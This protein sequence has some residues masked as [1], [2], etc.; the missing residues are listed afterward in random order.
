MVPSHRLGILRA[1]ERPRLPRYGLLGGASN[2][3]PA[4]G[5]P[6][7]LAA[8]AASRK[9][10]AEEKRKAEAE[11]QNDQEIHS[12][13]SNG[14]LNRLEKRQ[15]LKLEVDEDKVDEARKG[16]K[17]LSIASAPGDHARADGRLLDSDTMDEKASTTK[18][19]YP[20]RYQQPPEQEA[21]PLQ[22]QHEASSVSV[23][24]PLVSE[25]EESLQAAPSS[26]ADSLFQSTQQ[27]DASLDVPSARGFDMH[28]PVPDDLQQ[29]YS[30]FSGP[31]P[32]DVV[33]RAQQGK[34]PQ[35]KPK[36]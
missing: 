32:D 18:R 25:F 13:G 28:F 1:P 33:I 31:S 30:P 9:K 12:G 29:N 23:Q 19:A 15:K 14:T 3:S 2:A 27:G 35:P 4:T 16:V 5:K 8:L 20:R 22:E 7:K 6:S 26:L 24:S 17:S 11:A 34:G 36:H 10:A 21:V